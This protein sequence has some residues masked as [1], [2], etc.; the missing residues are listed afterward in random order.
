MKFKTKVLPNSKTE[1]VVK[2]ADGILKIK[3][4]EPAKEGKANKRCVELLSKRFK[5][6]KSYIK[7]IKG[8]KS[9]EKR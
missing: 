8:L 7:I 2:E 4:K 1:G 3:V 6:P 9:K 5:V